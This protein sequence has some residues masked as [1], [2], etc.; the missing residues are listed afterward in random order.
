KPL[1]FDAKI[2][3]QI[4]A[5]KKVNGVSYEST[6][7]HT[8]IAD[9]FGHKGLDE[10]SLSKYEYNVWTKKIEIDH[11]GAKDDSK[12]IKDFCDNL[13]WTTIVPELKIKPI[14]H[15][16]KDIQT[17]EVTKADIELLKE[18]ASVWALVW[19][20]VGYSVRASVGDSVRASVGDSVWALV[21]TSVWASVGDS[22]WASVWYSVGD[23]VGDSV[24]ASVGYSVG[25]YIATFVDTKYK[26]NLEPAQKLWGRGLVASFDGTNWK[27]HGAGGKEVYKVSAKELRKIK[28]RRENGSS[29]FTR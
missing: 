23:S 5:K 12:A 19:D 14:I 28:L 24:R 8:S 18:W 6:D 7:S 10:D 27:L 13:D 4:I 15:P 17:L 22:V 3:K 29:Y 21:W 16:F 2:R 26:Y 20:S 11:L 1:Y 25:A 9:Y